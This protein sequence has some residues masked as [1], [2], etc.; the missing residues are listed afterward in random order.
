[1]ASDLSDW[2]WVQL[3]FF[4][5]GEVVIDREELRDLVFGNITFEYEWSIILMSNSRVIVWYDYVG[6]ERL[7]YSRS[8]Q[9]QAESP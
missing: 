7:G 4:R 3:V 2:I 1:M 8:R 6:Y 5:E 9:C